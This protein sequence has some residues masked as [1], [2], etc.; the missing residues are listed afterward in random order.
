MHLFIY[1]YLHLK[2][3]RHDVHF[4]FGIENT[5]STSFDDAIN[6]RSNVHINP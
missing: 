5:C 4:I 6:V 3:W 1:I 2:V